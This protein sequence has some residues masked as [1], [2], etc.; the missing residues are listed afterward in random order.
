M[1]V[2]LALERLREANPWA[3]LVSQSSQVHIPQVQ[4]LLSQNN[5]INSVKGDKQDKQHGPL[6]SI[7]LEKWVF[8]PLTTA[9]K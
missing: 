8:M 2:I 3:L 9:S 6:A 7:H 5:N 4:Q 1:P